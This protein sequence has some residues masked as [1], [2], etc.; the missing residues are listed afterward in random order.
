MLVGLQ[1]VEETLD[2]EILPEL[3]SFHKQVNKSTQQHTTRLSKAWH[4]T[5]ET[6]LYAM[7]YPSSIRQARLSCGHCLHVFHAVRS[8][9]AP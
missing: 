2:V 1:I 3:R 8:I 6:R 9:V 7:A 5:D 4:L